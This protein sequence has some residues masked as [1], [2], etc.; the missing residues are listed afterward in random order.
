MISSHKKLNSPMLTS[1]S[2]FKSS[3]IDSKVPQCSS[4]AD[5]ISNH[6]KLNSPK[7]TTGM[8]QNTNSLPFS[9]LSNLTSHHLQKSLGSTRPFQEEGLR[10]KN[11]SSKKENELFPKTVLDVKNSFSDSN[12][13]TILKDVA[14]LNF[15]KKDGKTADDEWEID[16]SS[17]LRTVDL[18]KPKSSKVEHSETANRENYS[19]NKSTFGGSNFDACFFNLHSLRN[20][21]LQYALKTASPLGKVLCRK[22]KTKEPHAK[23]KA[24]YFQTS[25]NVTRFD[26]SVPSP[27]SVILQY[28]R[29]T[30]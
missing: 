28:L 21:E 14:S 24:W 2:G 22:W 15:G 16:L 30:T 3:R 9:S 23:R 18:A 12:V 26:F 4:L 20:A 17:A 7:S 11:F 29:K 19:T 27:D 13:N 1:F 5:L 10:T 8:S 25:P 6:K